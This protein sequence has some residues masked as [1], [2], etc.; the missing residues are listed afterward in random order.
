M[1]EF[2]RTG[3]F[4]PIRIS[5]TADKVRRIFGEPHQTGGTTRRRRIPGIWKYGD[6]EFHLTDDRQHIW[7]IFCDTFQRL[8]LGSAATLDHWFFEGH[9]SQEDVER[10]LSAA[11]ISSRR[12]DMAHE[13]T[14]YWLCLESGVKL[15]FSTGTDPVM[16]PGVPGLFGFTWA[17]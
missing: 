4:G 2:L 8:H 9:P 14:G 16:H 10:E 13:P 5:D 11:N 7:L 12:V 17:R 15:Q 1:R 3:E 6:V